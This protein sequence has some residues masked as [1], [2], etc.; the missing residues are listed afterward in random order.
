V[1]DSREREREVE[2]VPFFF[3]LCCK[4]RFVY[5]ISLYTQ[6]SE[7]SL[8][9]NDLRLRFYKIE[10]EVRR[11]VVSHYSVSLVENNATMY[12]S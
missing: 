7:T 1:N 12:S 6:V 4:F 5:I 10:S 2:K 11:H 3:F 9:N 8:L